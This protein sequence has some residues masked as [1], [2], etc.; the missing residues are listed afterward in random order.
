MRAVSILV[1][2]AEPSAVERVRG[3]YPEGAVVVR[4]ETAADAFRTLAIAV[5]DVL[6]LGRLPARDRMALTL[7]V[8][9]HWRL[10]HARSTVVRLL[11]PP[12]DMPSAGPGADAPTLPRPD[13]SALALWDELALDVGLA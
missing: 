3:L 6:V 9:K 7:A 8:R 4:A 2:D 1:V 5:F 10:P 13:P 12:S 11:G